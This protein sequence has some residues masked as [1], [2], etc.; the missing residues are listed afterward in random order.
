MVPNELNCIH[1]LVFKMKH[2]LVFIHL[3]IWR[4]LWWIISR[5]HAFQHSSHSL[6]GQKNLRGST[7]FSFSILDDI[8]MLKHTLPTMSLQNEAHRKDEFKDELVL[9]ASARTAMPM[10]STVVLSSLPLES[11]TALIPHIPYVPSNPKK[12]KNTPF[13]CCST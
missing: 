7:Q 11:S 2:E 6:S 8:R 13:I 4:I 1:Y 5:K 3:Y 12:L 9:F 10:S